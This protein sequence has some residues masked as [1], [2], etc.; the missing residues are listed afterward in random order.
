MDGIKRFKVF[1]RE[2]HL[3]Y[4]SEKQ[5]G[6]ESNLCWRPSGN[7]IA[8]T[9]KLADKH[10]VSFFEKNGLKHGEFDISDKFVDIEDIEWS[11]DSEVLTL[12]CRSKRTNTQI[13]LL[14][15]TSNYH[16]YLKQAIPFDEK[17]K[18]SKIMW[19]NDF[20][21]ANNKKLHVI[22]HDGTYYTFNWIWNIDHSSGNCDKDDSIVAVIDGNKILLTGFRQTVVPPPMSA[23]E[24]KLDMFVNSV[25]FAPK[26]SDLDPNTFFVCTSNNK[27]LFYKQTQKFPLQYKEYKTVDL[28]KYD[29]PFQNY[30]WYWVTDDTILCV[31]AD[32][33][34]SYNLVEYTIGCSKILKKNSVPLLSTAVTRIQAHPINI[35][36]LFLELNNGHI[37]QYE[38][39]GSVHLHDF[40]F[41]TPCPKFDV[42]IID[43]IL[44]F[45]G[46]SHKGNL[47]LND[48]MIM[49]NVSSYFIHTHFL[50]LTTLQHVLICT[51]LTA[52]GL[53]AIKNYQKNESE[54]VYKRKMER[55]AKL[56]IAVPHDTRTIFQMSRGN[57]ET[58]QPRPLSLKIIGEHLN[59]C[60]YYEAFDLMRKQRINLNLLYDHDPE[61]FVK[62]IDVFLDTID[63]NSWLNLFLSDL[64]NIDVTKTMYG[65]CY[66]NSTDNIKTL[67]DTKVQG[68]CDI[69]RENLLKRSDTDNKVLPILTTFVKKNNVMDLER[70]LL[71]V[72]ELKLKE[73]DGLKLPV[74]SDEALKYLLYMVDV[75]QLFD[76]ALGMYDFDLVLLV[77]NKSHKDPKEYIPMLNELN[78][79]NENYKRFS[80]NKHLKRFDKA[81]NCLVKCGPEKYNE[82]KIFVKYHS[83]YRE[84][85]SHFST[86]NKIFQEISEDYGSYLK[87]KKQFIEAGIIF[88][89]ASN[90]DKAVECYKEALEWE[91]A[92]SLAQ[93]WPK[94]SLQ[95][96]CW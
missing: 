63:N 15:T 40:T 57:L 80:I 79:M 46:L 82:L 49:N 31:T 32:K 18:I 29:F 89:R 53:N 11:S 95:E 73:C 33:Y 1:D 64:E 7:L 6:L 76:V 24:I 36:L 86:E 2:G 96:L 13:L 65:S 23:L 78:E 27:L 94:E 9:Q 88:E 34:N 48:R 39:G 62:N 44:N 8:T 85:L 41:D 35:R 22:L 38:L 74:T 59:N 52:A 75:N 61:K 81:V 58:I 68:I 43:N 21:V 84:A 56:V 90:I 20:D 17:Q 72:K 69:V 77:A 5:Q 67:I 87:L 16:W 54:K 14:Y 3:Q 10:L 4:T 12:L 28:D 47:F 92:I 50:L 83:L 19:D 71:I 91:I 45:I 26:T 93:T 25:N 60:K 30:N 42:F 55:G 51:E 66:A 37:A 70:A